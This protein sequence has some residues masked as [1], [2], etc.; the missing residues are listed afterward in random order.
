MTISTSLR[1][2]MLDC[3]RL[4]GGGT[5]TTALK[6]KGLARSRFC[7]FR[8]PEACARTHISDATPQISITTSQ[9]LGDSELNRL[10]SGSLCM[11]IIG[12][13]SYRPSRKRSFQVRQHESNPTCTL[14]RRNQG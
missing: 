13:R 3:L 14:G 2:K 9:V 5:H 8:S 6:E 10:I 12:F 1:G 4:V 7:Q 11:R